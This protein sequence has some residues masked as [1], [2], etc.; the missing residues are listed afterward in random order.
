ML[1]WPATP[2]SCF[3]YSQSAL[4]AFVHADRQERCKV[5]IDPVNRLV[6][7]GEKGHPRAPRLSA[8]VNSP[9]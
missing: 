9:R 6:L 4:G 1:G 5:N 8:Q 3:P 2:S 7:P